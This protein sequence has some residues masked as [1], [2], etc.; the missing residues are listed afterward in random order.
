M[1]VYSAEEQ[2]ERVKQDLLQKFAREDWH[3]VAD[4][5]M[6]LSRHRRVYCGS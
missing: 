6:D 3:G 1:N 2:R 5:A 4:A